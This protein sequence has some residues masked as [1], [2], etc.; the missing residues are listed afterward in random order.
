MAVH[1][2]RKK[3]VLGLVIAT[4]VIVY[5]QEADFSQQDNANESIYAQE[6]PQTDE[7]LTDKQNFTAFIDK[8]GK[9]VSVPIKDDSTLD[10]PVL[11]MPKSDTIQP[12]EKMESVAAK[13]LVPDVPFGTIDKVEEV[14]NPDITSASVV[15]QPEMTPITQKIGEELETKQTDSNTSVGKQQQAPWE[16]KSDIDTLVETQKEP[17]IV[18][19]APEKVATQAEVLPTSDTESIPAINKVSAIVKSEE[20]LQNP[21]EPVKAGSVK[22]E[23]SKEPVKDLA[24]EGLVSQSSSESQ[25]QLSSDN[26]AKGT[27]AMPTASTSSAVPTKTSSDLEAEEDLEEPKGIST[28]EFKESHGN[29]LFKRIWW[30]RAEER[31]QRIRHVVEQVY[32]AR[33][34]F[35]SKRTEI[36]KT[37]LDPFY[38]SIGLGQGELRELLADIIRR[39][40]KLKDEA[41]SLNE[42]ER[43]FLQELEAEKETLNQLQ[44]D[45]DAIIVLDHDI[46]TALNRLMEQVNRV[47]DYERSAWDA[48]REI[49]QV[50]SDKRAQ[51]LYYQMETLWKNAKD[52]HKYVMNDYSQH[53]TIVSNKIAAETKRISETIK[54]LKEKGISLRDQA[55]KLEQA[56]R[57]AYSQQETANNKHAEGE[58]AVEQEEVEQSSLWKKISITFWYI[59]TAPSRLLSKIVGFFTG[60]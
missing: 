36:D 35:F 23:E 58:N 19:A 21:M 5:A 3:A 14:K 52:V 24:K 25:K 31:Y 18:V 44:K 30:E 48:L 50:L 45:I 34:T 7:S 39:L 26:I 46:D 4:S 51:E 13:E 60:N 37:I 2:S 49:G 32:E 17:Q 22:V 10:I 29:W 43:A 42:Y 41:G 33:M 27:V 38:F 12:K 54:Q 20:Q 40:D 57:A 47:R 28:V 56:D 6:Q 1:K 11:P 59:L 16:Q 15:P 55:D 53:F 8:D 9:L